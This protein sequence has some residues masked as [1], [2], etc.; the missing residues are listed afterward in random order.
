MSECRGIWQI[1]LTILGNLHLQAW[2]KKRQWKCYFLLLGL[3]PKFQG[4]I[5]SPAQLRNHHFFLYQ[6]N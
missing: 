6:S 3:I 4:L 2:L 5:K 1:L